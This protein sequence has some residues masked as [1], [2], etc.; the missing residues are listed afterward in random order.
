M[1]AKL[2]FVII[3]IIIA[4]VFNHTANALERDIIPPE[5]SS[6]ESK[7][8]KVFYDPSVFSKREIRRGLVVLEQFLKE[9]C[10]KSSFCRLP[11]NKIPIVYLNEKGPARGSSNLRGFV[12]TIDDVRGIVVYGG[13]RMDD[14]LK[15][16]DVLRHEMCHILVC[17]PQHW[18]NEGYATLSENH[19]KQD[20]RLKFAYLAQDKLPQIK[21]LE[22]F[23]TKYDLSGFDDF[24]KAM[25]DDKTKAYY[26]VS[27]SLTSWLIEKT[28]SLDK[29]IEFMNELS[30]GTGDSDRWKEYAPEAYERLQKKIK[31][32]LLGLSCWKPEQNILKII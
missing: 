29:F 9:E 14:Y 28:G 16:D 5:Y 13:K 19:R 7:S 21:I 8:F 32:F 25:R 4:T 2:I 15:L 11:D 3:F 31:D 27:F 26:G 12:T 1:R 17:L 20:D 23:F 18:A 30:E 22:E 6:Q 10:A 24:L